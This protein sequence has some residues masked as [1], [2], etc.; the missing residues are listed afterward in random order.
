MREGTNPEVLGKEGERRKGEKRREGREGEGR[1][2]EGREGGLCP[3]GGKRETEW[4]DLGVGMQTGS[5]GGA[6]LLLWL[7]VLNEGTHMFH[8]NWR[9]EQFCCQLTRYRHTVKGIFVLMEK[10]Q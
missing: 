4:Q 7:K 1:G 6:G 9:E 3:H 2:E 8:L 5:L 10:P